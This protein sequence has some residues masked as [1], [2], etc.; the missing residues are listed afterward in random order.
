MNDKIISIIMSCIWAGLIIMSFWPAVWLSFILALFYLQP[1]LFVQC[2]LL[3]R[4]YTAG[5]M[6]VWVEQ[7]DVEK[8][9]IR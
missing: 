8:S 5:N 9:N 2:M 4:D 7:I 3:W 6:K 1:S